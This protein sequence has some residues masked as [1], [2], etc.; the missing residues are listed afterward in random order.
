MDTASGRRA[1][2]HQTEAAFNEHSVV[3][4]SQ[5][6]AIRYLP[7][8]AEDTATTEPWGNEKP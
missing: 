3:A 4:N 7:R 1:A 8:S 2:N 5:C 6:R